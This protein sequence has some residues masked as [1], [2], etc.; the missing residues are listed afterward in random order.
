MQVNLAVCISRAQGRVACHKKQ[1]EPPCSALYQVHCIL[2]VSLIHVEVH[3][4]TAHLRA[5]VG[6]IQSRRCFLLH[7]LQS[8][9]NGELDWWDLFVRA[10]GDQNVLRS[11]HLLPYC[12]Y[13]CA[14]VTLCNRANLLSTWQFSKQGQPQQNITLKLS[15][16]LASI[17]W[18]SS[19]NVF[20][21][22]SVS[23]LGNITHV[24]TFKK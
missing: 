19:T 17:K 10:F 7:L 23:H 12:F 6:D 3:I 13:S 16:G 4:S 22:C 24:V 1:A 11:C 18:Q 20:F 21:S 5:A 9:M 14:L 8:F 2:P 15:F